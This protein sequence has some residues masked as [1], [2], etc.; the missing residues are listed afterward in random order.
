MQADVTPASE[1]ILPLVLPASVALQGKPQASAEPLPASQPGSG[2]DLR[3]L[4][5]EDYLFNR[6]LLKSQL[7]ALGHGIC[8]AGDGQEAWARCLVESFDLI[9]TDGRMPLM[10]GF[11]FIRRLRQREAENQLRRCRVIAL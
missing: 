3:I 6:E 7:A 4:A 5:V 9:I 8:L 10:D 11:E 2:S 1:G